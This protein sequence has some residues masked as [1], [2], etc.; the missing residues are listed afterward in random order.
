MLELF[1][2]CRPDHRKS[3]QLP[4]RCLW[5]R[6]R[7]WA[8]KVITLNRAA[9]EPCPPD[10]RYRT[11]TPYN[12]LV[13]NVKERFLK[14]SANTDLNEAIA[15]HRSVLDLRLAGHSKW[16]PSLHAFAL[17]L[18]HWYRKW[19]N[20]YDLD[21]AIT[22][23]PAV[24]EL[25]PPDHRH[26]V[27]AP[28]SP[29]PYLRQEF[30]KLGAN[31]D[32]G[33]AIALS[34]SALDPRR[35]GHLDWL[36]LNSLIYRL[37]SRFKKGWAAEDLDGL[38]SLPRTI[39]DLQPLGHL[40]YVMSLRKPLFHIQKW[41]RR[42]DMTEDLD[43]CTLPEPALVVYVSWSLYYVKSLCN[44]DLRKR[45]Q[46]V[47]A[48]TDL[49]EIITLSR[50]IVVLHPPGCPNH[51][52]D[53][54]MDTVNDALEFLPPRLLNTHTGVICGQDAL[55]S[56]FSNSQQYKLLLSSVTTCPTTLRDNIH[57]TVSTYF[58]YVTLS[59]RWDKDDPLLCRIQGRT[60]Y[61]MDPTKVKGLLKLQTFCATALH[62]GYL[63]AWSDTCCVDKDN[64]VKP[65]KAMES[66][67]SWYRRSALTIVYLFDV[68]RD[69]K[70]S[71]STWFKRGWTLQELLAPRKILFY[72]QDWSLYK[73]SP[74][75]N[76]KEDDAVLTELE[77]ATGIA[78]HYLT[79]FNPG[80]D[81]A[82]SRLQWASGRQT[83]EP[84]DLAY[85]LFG[86]F[87]A[88]LS[89][90]PGES[91]ENALGRLLTEIISKSGDL[92]VLDWVGEASSY[93]SCFPARIASYGSL[94]PTYSK[95]EPR[96]PLPNTPELVEARVKLLNSL[97]TLEHPRFIGR[98][99]RLPCI[100]YQITAVELKAMDTKTPEYVYNIRAEGLLPFKIALSYELKDTS[101]P[102]LPFVLI[103][104][105]HSK[106]LPSFI[107][108]GVSDKLDARLTQPF[109]ALL[110]EEQSGNYYKRI[111][112]SS[113][114]VACSADVTTSAFKG[115]PQTIT[116][117]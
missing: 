3:L 102:I 55:R 28:Q 41:L 40:D 39:L 93:H 1:P 81:N 25:L 43:K 11:K 52:M 35:E 12:H 74:S 10:H 103:R 18:R 91:A 88:D 47:G 37:S 92:S 79:D 76:H 26:H 94:P 48:I 110:L 111:A 17:C 60:I 59:H 15:P 105:W 27:L 104:L 14:L 6:C 96:T 23:E 32:L 57:N 64:N 4:V 29:V 116:V 80:F 50:T 99:L 20:L 2:A 49:E 72:T 75:S 54:I 24:L 45:F 112:S 87:N 62:C 34:R 73:G 7:K 22:H 9:L 78:R 66:M 30:M 117:L 65:T 63:W 31:A 44:F 107:E 89:F 109:S 51:V 36:S 84:E 53:L 115:E 86:I 70:L 97:S 83:T 67:F 85:S 46:K 82:R 38:L 77:A 90:S 16:P 113:V 114:I 95:N 98:Q 21:G 33:E 13:D 58:E 108:A 56:A 101:R 5:R 8:K 71:S 42:L 61:H 106:P 100:V 69:G 19:V 68:S